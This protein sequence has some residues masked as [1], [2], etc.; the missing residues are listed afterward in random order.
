MTTNLAYALPTPGSVD[1]Y[2]PATRPS[3][4][5]AVSPRALR[6]P[7]P[8]LVYGLVATGVIFGIFM[9]QLLLTI[10]LS[11]GAYSI[12]HLQGT[13]RDLARQSSALSEK[14]DTLGSAQHLS[15]DAQALGMVGSSSMAFMQASDGKVIGTA[16]PA[17]GG[18]ASP[19]STSAADN[20][21]PNSLLSGLSV[22]TP[23]GSGHGATNAAQTPLTGTQSNSSTTNAGSSLGSSTG[24]SSQ[25]GDS[26]QLPSPQTH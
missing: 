3:R 5:R 22:I 21:V 9:A 4:I 25:S 11:G 17:K 15:S 26:G 8:K 23:T 7:K 19:S 24:D 16:T 13:Q 2:A 18:G 10:S 14:L 1:D 20:S 6:R 12:S